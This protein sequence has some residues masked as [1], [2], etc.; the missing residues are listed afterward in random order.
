MI[1]V[2]TVEATYEFLRDLP[3][4]KSAV[5]THADDVEFR[6][7]NRRDVNE[8][9]GYGP[10]KKGKRAL[11][12][13]VSVRNVTTLHSLMAAVAHGMIHAAQVEADR[14]PVHDDWFY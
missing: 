14:K 12:L 13:S 4:F 10:K 6:L 2:R 7:V 9:F 1:S 11:H 5:K 3:P 8:E